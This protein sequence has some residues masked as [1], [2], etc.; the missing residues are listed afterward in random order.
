MKV[1]SLHLKGF[2]QGLNREVDPYLLGET[3]VPHAV[4]VDFGARGEIGRR[5]GYARIDFPWEMPSPE[6]RIIS[7]ESDDDHFL[8]VI[9]APDRDVWIGSLITDW[10]FPA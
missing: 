8:V 2:P 9:G 7:W 3:E 5:N 10:N 4:N 1:E 6:Q